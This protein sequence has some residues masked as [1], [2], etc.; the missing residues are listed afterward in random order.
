LDTLALPLT[1]QLVKDAGEL[2]LGAAY[3]EDDLIEQNAEQ[4]KVK[5]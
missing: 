5:R 4:L 3:D 2:C 1:A